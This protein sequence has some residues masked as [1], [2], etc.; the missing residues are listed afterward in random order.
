M[1]DLVTQLLLPRLGADET[2]GL[3]R[4][5]LGASADTAL[6]G[7]LVARSEGVP[8]YAEELARS[9][10]QGVGGLPTTLAEVLS[11]RLSELTEDSRRVLEAA[12]VGG[13]DIG[14]DD[15]AAVLD[16]TGDRVDGALQ[17]GIDR[18][19]LAMTGDAAGVRFRHALLREA[20]LDG[21]LPGRLATLHRRWAEHLGAKPA[22]ESDAGLAVRVAQHWRA[23]HD[24]G[25]A[26][27]ASLTAARLLRSA[28]APAEELRMLEQALGL[29]DAGAAPHLV[30]DRDR[31]AVQE[32][33]ALA[34]SQ[35]GEA[36]RALKCQTE[37]LGGVHPD[38][39]PIRHAS[40]RL[41][42]LRLT[43]PLGQEVIDE[44]EHVL[45]MLP[46]TAP[47]TEAGRVRARA[48]LQT[49]T[50]QHHDGQDR[51]WRHRSGPRRRGLVMD[52]GRR[53]LCHDVSMQLLA[54]YGI[55]R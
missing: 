31:A 42:R 9:A 50:D 36:E 16:L 55:S 25:N 3:V 43:E 30:A 34:A 19:I 11:A 49:R 12:A 39:E 6:V 1:A 28:A 33:A 44:T 27:A 2:A 13:T 35:A 41:E 40:M 24:T 29:W 17:E 23:A 38:R 48:R 21:L 15:V 37:S 20:A 53:G 45:A 51:T 4:R 47:D 14:E 26:F 54:L 8:F 7:S 18:H 5:R 52:Q 46:P 22:A 10:A 32:A